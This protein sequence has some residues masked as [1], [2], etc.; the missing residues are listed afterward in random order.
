LAN[1]THVQSQTFN[2]TTQGRI[3]QIEISGLPPGSSI[4]NGTYRYSDKNPNVI[5]NAGGQPLN[6]EDVQKIQQEILNPATARLRAQYTDRAGNTQ[7]GQQGNAF[8]ADG[9]NFVMFHY[10]YRA[11][12]DVT[13]RVGDKDYT[14]IGNQ[15]GNQYID[16]T[17]HQPLDATRDRLIIAQINA[18]VTAAKEDVSRGGVLTGLV[19]SMSPSD[20]FVAP[21][22]VQDISQFNNL[23]IGGHTSRYYSSYY[24]RYVSGTVGATNVNVRDIVHNRQNGAVV[25]TFNSEVNITENGR[26]VNLNGVHVRYGQ[27]ADGNF[28][29]FRQEGSE[30]KPITD[31]GA[32]RAVGETAQAINDRS[33]EI[34]DYA[35]KHRDAR[36]SYAAL[37]E[38][39]L[40]AVQASGGNQNVTPGTPQISTGPGFR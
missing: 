34:L 24:G 19:Q 29:A 31:Q 27:G 36:H 11:P 12:N 9:N 35:Y 30:W 2:S 21:S 14:K 39:Q 8:A 38:Y 5:V 28:Y 3:R 40:P 15:Y 18:R 26:P 32:V 33:R 22:G 17:T 1:G 20:R 23:H 6:Q 7:D 10:T 16:D 4:S 13:V 37:G 25:F